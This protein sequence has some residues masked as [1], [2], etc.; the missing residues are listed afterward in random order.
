LVLDHRPQELHVILAAVDDMLFSSKIRATARQVGV[1]VIFARS[2]D[3]I[4][5]QAR[6]MPAL[7]IFDLNSTRTDPVG[8][9]TAL[10]A[11]PQL[12]PIRTI[13]FVS[14]VQTAL[15]D[16]ARRAGADEV[17]ARSAFAANLGEILG[18]A[19]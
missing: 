1:D 5:Q 16:A 6:A 17:M 4:L 2:P 9:I 10:K 15:I 14:H 8:T 13:G 7:A 19:R 11:D 3:E 12:A 18:S